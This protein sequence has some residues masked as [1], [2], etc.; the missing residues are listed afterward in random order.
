MGSG[1]GRG[2]GGPMGRG[3]GGP[4]RGG[5]GRGGNVGIWQEG[6]PAVHSQ[7]L[8][9]LED[10]VVARFKAEND[11]SPE[12]PLRTF[13][14]SNGNAVFTIHFEGP[15]WG[16]LGQPGAV[17]ANFFTI[18]L[19]KDPIYDYKVEIT[20]NPGLGRVKERIFHLLERDPKISPLARFIAHDKGER[21]VSARQLEQPLEVTINH[22]GEGASPTTVGRPYQV[23]ITFVNIL[24]PNGLTR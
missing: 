2:R 18:R 22:T 1:D 21:L 16:T 14:Q 7:Q 10:R 8:R 19:P 5:R 13:L 6:V 3:G 11:N 12:L 23:E 9:E 20:P 15:G 4:G 17:R 24:D